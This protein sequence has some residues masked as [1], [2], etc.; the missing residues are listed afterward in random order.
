MSGCLR[1]KIKVIHNSDINNYIDDDSSC[2]DQ[3][4]HYTKKQHTQCYSLLR[5]FVKHHILILE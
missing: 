2:E 1:Y 4:T 5:E 3:L